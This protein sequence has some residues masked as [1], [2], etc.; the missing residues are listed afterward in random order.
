MKKML[1]L[2]CV[3]AA[4]FVL[5]LGTAAPPAYAIKPF[6]DQFTARYVKK[7][8]KEQK[9]IDFAKL[10]GE[11]KCNVCHSG[12]TKKERNP[13]GTE[14]ANLLDKATDKDNPAKIL[15][16]FDKVEKLPSNPADKKS[17]TF[18]DLIKTGKLPGGTPAP[19]EKTG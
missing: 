10:V 16:A 5:A 15:S 4:V 11:T 19:T 12:K 13:Y 2:P 18:G 3:V 6:S 14:L 9:D 8:S 17:P 7:D 1:P